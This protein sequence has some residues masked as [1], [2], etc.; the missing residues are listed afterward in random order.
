MVVIGHSEGALHAARLSAAVN[1]AATV[2]LSGAARSGSEVLRWRHRS[3]T[4][5]ATGMGGWSRDVNEMNADWAEQFLA[6]DPRSDLA[7]ITTPV[8]AVTGDKDLEV[9][10]EDLEAIAALVPGD[11]E[12]HRPTH[13]THLVRT[14]PTGPSVADYARQVSEPMDPAVIRMTLAWLDSVMEG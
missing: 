5:S 1:P 4:D 8:L 3:T 6:Y 14:D 11:C 2:L 13:L 12:S 9:P 10:P 7:R